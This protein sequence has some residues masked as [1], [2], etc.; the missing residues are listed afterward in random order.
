MYA[1]NLKKLRKQLNISVEKLAKSIDIP[2]STLWG[3]ESKK[4]TPSIDLPIRLY[5]IYNV[6]TNWFLTGE[7][8]MFNSPSQ[9]INSTNSDLRSEVLKI[10]KEE[11]V[12]KQ[13]S[14]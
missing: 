2:A 14:V 13:H 8:E 5:R 4:R 7:G 1:E 3:Y 9:P 10:L 11:G 12:I 6:N